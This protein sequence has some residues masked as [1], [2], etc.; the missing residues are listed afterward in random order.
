MKNTIKICEI[1]WVTDGEEV[2]LPESATIDIAELDAYSLE[3]DDDSST[4]N[5]E[6]FNEAILD[7][8]SNTYGWLVSGY[9]R[10]TNGEKRK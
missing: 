1:D 3:F 10:D 7:H 4:L 6:Q 8:L 9:T 5:S 2:D